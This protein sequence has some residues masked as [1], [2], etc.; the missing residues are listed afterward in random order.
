MVPLY[1]RAT[2]SYIYLGIHNLYEQ[3]EGRKIMFSDEF[4]EHPNYI[5][6]VNVLSN[7]VALVKLPRKVE[8]TGKTVSTYRE[9]FQM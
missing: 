9:T 6:K 3:E 4:Y 5:R 7:D 1:S 2:E 8:Y